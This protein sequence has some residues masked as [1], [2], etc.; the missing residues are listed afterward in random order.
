VSA[1]EAVQ[2]PLI[3]LDAEDRVI[4]VN[5]AAS[6]MITGGDFD[7]EHLI[8]SR[9]IAK[10]AL[11]ADEISAYRCQGAKGGKAI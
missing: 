6:G 2:A 1:I 11:G 8:G 5:A 3:V 7:P 4:P 9:R 10:Q